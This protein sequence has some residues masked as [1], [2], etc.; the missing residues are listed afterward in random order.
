M[1]APAKQPKKVA[2]EIG[3]GTPART[4]RHQR[5]PERRQVQDRR[6][7]DRVGVAEAEVVEQEAAH[8]DGEDDREIPVID[9]FLE[10]GDEISATG[11][12]ADQQRDGYEQGDL[13]Q[14]TNCKVLR[15]LAAGKENGS[16]VA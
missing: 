10:Q 7:D 12:A 14:S 1:K 3:I 8:S 13:G 4:Q 16:W 5:R 2:G 15:C 9:G 11:R 6:D